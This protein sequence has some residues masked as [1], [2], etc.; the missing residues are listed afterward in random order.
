MAAFNKRLEDYSGCLV[1]K[2]T[3]DEDARRRFPVKSDEDLFVLHFGHDYSVDA[4]QK[5]APSKAFRRLGFKTQVL[6]ATSNAHVRNRLIHTYEVANIATTIARIL[7]LN[8]NLCLAIALGHDI[9]HAPFGHAGETFI[10][11]ITGKKFRHELFGVVVAQQIE[12]QGKGLNLTRQVLE[13]ILNHSRGR[14]D[15]KRTEDIFEEANVV[16][17]ADKIAYVWAD[18]ADIFERT[19]TLDY[20]KFPKIK[21]LVESCGAKHRER[22]TYCI[23]NLCYE[24]AAAGQ[25][26]FEKS[27]AAKIFFNIK[28]QM[29]DVYNLVNLQN[30]DEVLGRVY[31]FLSKTELIGGADPAVVLAL[32]TD[33]D[34]LSLFEKKGI[35]ARD[36]YDC[37]VAEIIG[38]LK[39]KKI[40]FFDPDLDW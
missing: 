10:S 32:M 3:R 30:P 26:S 38:Y 31:D 8:E 12:R 6:T 11:K 40:N 20:G 5:I 13:G 25:V 1:H 29:Y 23:E 2:R 34:V 18:I 19:K 9:G 17:Y 7:G 14:S 4:L 35:N 39:G 33:S 16:M 28:D 36:F 24:S 27:E 22:T 21:K 15:P 37:S